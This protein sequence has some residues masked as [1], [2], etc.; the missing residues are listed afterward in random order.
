MLRVRIAVVLVGVLLPG[1]LLRGE[2]GKDKDPPKHVEGTVKSVDTKDAQAPSLTV[3]VKEKQPTEKE[4]VFKEVDKDYRFR[5]ND[6]TRILGPDG[7]PD[8]QGL[9]GLDTGRRVRVE[10]R[11]DLALEVKPLPP[12]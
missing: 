5:V 10:Y 11:K 1:A 12:R 8:K 4:D 7:K 9:K 3:T 2:G 6:S